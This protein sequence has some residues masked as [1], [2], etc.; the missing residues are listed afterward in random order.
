MPRDDVTIAQGTDTRR[1][2]NSAVDIFCAAANGQTVPPSG[3]LSL[4]TE[5]YLNGGKTPA[6]YG[7]VGF[8]SC[9][10]NLYH[11]GCEKKD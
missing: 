7:V 11:N 4:A 2:F 9:G 1:G 8:V 10:S 5:V 6:T 3:Y